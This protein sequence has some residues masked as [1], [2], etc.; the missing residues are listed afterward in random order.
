MELSNSIKYYEGAESAPSQYTIENVTMD[1]P[2]YAEEPD[3]A[4]DEGCGS[5]ECDE[6]NCPQVSTW[7]I[8]DMAKSLMDEKDYNDIKAAD[9]EVEQ[10]YEK[11]VDALPV[12]KN[13]EAAMIEATKIA[14]EADVEVAKINAE[15][16]IEVAKINTNG[17]CCPKEIKC[18]RTWKNRH[19]DKD[20]KPVITLDK[21]IMDVKGIKIAITGE[22][23]DKYC[24][25]CFW[26]FEELESGNRQVNEII[27]NKI[28]N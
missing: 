24:G 6:C 3:Q 25:S 27:L 19:D 1:V 9:E 22:D 4:Y 7:P 17:A 28:L 23:I 26:T 5:C 14:K 2:A 18:D 10:A 16:N 12:D 20:V 13:P 8:E 21:I 15:A 11:W